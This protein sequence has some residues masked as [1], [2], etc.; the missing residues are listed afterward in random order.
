V[1]YTAYGNHKTAKVEQ[2][3][4]TLKGN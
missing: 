1:T 4:R 2:V 3:A